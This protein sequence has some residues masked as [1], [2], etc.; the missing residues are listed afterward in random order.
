MLSLVGLS[1]SFLSYIAAVFGKF[2]VRIL[3]WSDSGSRGV[4]KA[5]VVF[6]FYDDCTILVPLV[7]SLSAMNVGGSFNTKLTG[8]IYLSSSYYFPFGL[9]LRYPNLFLGIVDVYL[10]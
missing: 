8:T 4:L 3:S 5:P 7:I 10:T 2:P 6:L 1:A 9:M